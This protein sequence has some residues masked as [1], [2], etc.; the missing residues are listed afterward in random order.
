MKLILAT[1]N[2]H[3]IREFRDMLK[4][5]KDF[6]ILSLRD[7]PSYVPPEETGSSFEENA[8]LKALIAAK[9]LKHLVLAD[10]SGLV[11]PSLNGEPGVFSARYAG[12]HAS[13]RE[14]REKL[15]NNLKSL[16]EEKRIG[17]FEC[18][19]AIATEEG[20]KKI[21]S[22]LCEG[23]LLLSPKGSH[24]FGYD[25]LFIKHEYSKTFA[26]M[27]DELKNRISHRR[28]AFDKLL[29]TLY[30]FSI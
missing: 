22:G 8:K 12:Q 28:K 10:D 23:R 3:K 7:F 2:L 9:H 4:G 30:S 18:S 14:N 19:I 16:P 26:E 21:T 20:L 24:G 17:Y 29:T 27:E 1:T 11:I 6:D 15:I 5:F 13:D 25:P